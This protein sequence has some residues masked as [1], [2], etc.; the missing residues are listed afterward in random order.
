[1]RAVGIALSREVFAPGDCIDGQVVVQSDKPFN[2]GHLSV[3]LC[4]EEMSRVVHGGGEDSHVHKEKRTHIDYRLPL[5]G[6]GEMPAGEGRFDFSFI[7]P[8]GI[9]PSYAGAHASISYVLKTNVD[10]PRAFDLNCSRSVQVV[11]VGSPIVRERKTGIIEH[12]GVRVLYIEVESDLIGP[13]V[14]IPLRFIL[15]GEAKCR[16]IRLQILSCESVAPEGCSKTSENIVS[17][18]YYRVDE[19]H[20]GLWAEHL[21]TMDAHLPPPF[22]TELIELTYSLKVTLDIPWGPDEQISIPLRTAVC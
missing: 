2:C 15:S 20:P 19:I 18:S 8:S 14:D 4:G 21:F 5:W 12:A 7:L 22:M 11:W 1:M 10:I 16:G 3:G 17:D 9:P 6:P 13:G